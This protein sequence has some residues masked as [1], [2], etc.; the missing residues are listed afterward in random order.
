M[1]KSMFREISRHQSVWYI[2]IYQDSIFP[3]LLY[4][5]TTSVYK[6]KNSTIRGKM[7]AE[8]QPSK[9]KIIL[10]LSRLEKVSCVLENTRVLLLSKM[11]AFSSKEPVFSCT[12][13]SSQ[14]TCKRNLH[15]G[16][17]EARI[18]CTLSSK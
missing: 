6:F 9:I 13:V 15:H 14:S 7:V 3:Q 4:K 10:S 2:C 17:N 11:Q 5:E 12:R 16:W 8:A 1:I 18:L